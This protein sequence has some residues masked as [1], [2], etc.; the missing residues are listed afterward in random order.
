MFIVVE[1]PTKMDDLGV[2]LGNPQIVILV[3][4]VV[5]EVLSVLVKEKTA[6]NRGRA[7]L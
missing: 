1:S 3:A 2:P 4:A 7:A 5:L 6:Q